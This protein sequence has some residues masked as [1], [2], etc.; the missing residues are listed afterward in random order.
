MSCLSLQ[1]YS[2]SLYSFLD[3]SALQK[4][5]WRQMKN[6]ERNRC[7]MMMRGKVQVVNSCTTV[8]FFL[9]LLGV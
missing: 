2:T 8:V 7:W 3:T 5:D 6:E 4:D 1:Y 9:S